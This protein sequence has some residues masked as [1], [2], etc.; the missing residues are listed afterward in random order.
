MKI[1]HIIVGLKTGGAEIALKRLVE[2][3][4]ENPNFR[5]E[6]VS[7]TDIGKVGV[8]L[9]GRGIKV[10]SLGMRSTIGSVFAL[11]RL[12]RLIRKVRPDIVQ[13]W[14]YHADLIGGLAARFAGVK[15]VVWGIRTTEICAGGSKLTIIIRKLCAVLS[16]LVPSVIVCVAEASK[17]LHV[18]LGYDAHRMVVIPNGFVAHDLRQLTKQAKALRKKFG[19]KDQDIVIGSVGRFN[20]VKDQQSFIHAA[21]IILNKYFN[22]YIIMAGRDINANNVELAKWIN[23]TGCGQRFILLDERDDVAVCM[24]AMDVFCLHSRAEGFPNVLGEA[25]A[26]ARASVSTDVGDAALLLGDCGLIVA[27]DNISVLAE[28]LEKIINYPKEEREILGQKARRR[29]KQYYTLQQ[30]VNQFEG[31]YHQ[32]ATEDLS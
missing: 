3:H 17:R 29:I 32:A 27:K 5:H 21:G 10:Q 30:T 22:V 20:A 18:A 15:N 23:E 4:A 31:I 12:I 1:L 2:A 28:G 25:M 24:K 26:V 9:I 19:F 11:W 8:H 16:A 6:V 14:M 7:L 13:T